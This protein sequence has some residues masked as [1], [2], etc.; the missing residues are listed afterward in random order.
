M[1]T[2][3]KQI[4]IVVKY[5]TDSLNYTIQKTFSKPKMGGV[6]FSSLYSLKEGQIIRIDSFSY[7][8][9]YKIWHYHLEYSFDDMEVINEVWNENK[10][11]DIRGQKRSYDIFVEDIFR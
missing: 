5:P 11:I 7:E 9:I 3:Y 4:A 8:L 10:K 2:V 1:N 6:N